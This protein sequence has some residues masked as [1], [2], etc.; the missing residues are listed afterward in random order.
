MKKVFSKAFYRVLTYLTDTHQDPTVAN[1]SLYHRKVVDALK[2]MGD[3][4]R[5]YPTMNQWVGFRLTKM[6][7]RH[8]ERNDGIWFSYSF[9]KRLNITF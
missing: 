7:I 9:K 5:Y 6:E 8:A 4:S 3:Y 1:Y 2:N